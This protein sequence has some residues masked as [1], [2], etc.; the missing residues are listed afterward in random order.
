[1]IVGALLMAVP[2]LTTTIWAPIIFILAFVPAFLIA[3]YFYKHLAPPG[4][5]TTL[6][7]DSLIGRTGWVKTDVS[8]G[9][10]RGKVMIEQEIWSA[11]SEQVIPEGTKVVV[12]NVVGV[13]VVVRPVDAGTKTGWEETLEV[14]A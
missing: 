7:S 11:T 8:P 3:F 12:T 14:D 2:D 4:K 1:M 13:K 6:S 10:I 5:P 9:N